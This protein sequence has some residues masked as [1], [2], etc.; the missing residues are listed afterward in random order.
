[1]LYD[2][3]FVLLNPHSYPRM[4]L[5]LYFLFTIY[6]ATAVFQTRRFLEN[7]YFEKTCFFRPHFGSL[8]YSFYINYIK[9]INKN[10]IFNASTYVKIKSCRR[11]RRGLQRL[12]REQPPCQSRAQGVN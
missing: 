12:P 8:F 7:A 2:V 4:S 10:T 9:Y 1:M 11:R 6:V 5:F 3:F